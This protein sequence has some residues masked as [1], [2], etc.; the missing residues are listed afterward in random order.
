MTTK[1]LRSAA[2][3]NGT[4]AAPRAAPGA[5]AH[6][7]NAAGRSFP[8]ARRR[9]RRRSGIVVE[10]VLHRSGKTILSMEENNKP[11]NKFQT[12]IDLL[13]DAIGKELSLIHI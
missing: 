2:P 3:A 8:N 4:C 13:N 10:R 7:S 11:Q 5:P 1:L 9:L 6:P 12:S